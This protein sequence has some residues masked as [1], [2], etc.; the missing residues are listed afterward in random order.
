VRDNGPVSEGRESWHAT[1][2][3]WALDLDREHV[4][5]IRRQPAVYSPGGPLHLVLEALAY[6]TDEAAYGD[7]PRAVVTLHADGS[8]SVVDN[9]RG[10]DTR[11]E[12]GR[13]VR[14]PVMATKD[15]RFFDSPGAQQLSDG[16]PRR[17]ISVV[18]ALSAWLV[19]TNH[20]GD[21]SWSQRYERGLPVSEL[22]PVP[23]DGTT[24]TAV[25]FRPDPTL[26][27]GQEILAQRLRELARPS[28]RL[29]VDVVIAC[30]TSR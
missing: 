15:L 25:H 27:A 14:K 9:G 22:V 20:R 18:S 1:T 6:P 4:E 7:A 21:G 24:G 12:G 11:S 19:H 29:A 13:P 16:H 23:D 30:R 10:T 26:F 17:G 3:D 5:L 28:S 2:H 8:V